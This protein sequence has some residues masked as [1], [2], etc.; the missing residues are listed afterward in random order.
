MAKNYVDI[1]NSVK[2]GN[3]MDWTNALQRKM[4][5]PVDLTGVYDSYEKAVIYAANDPVAYEGQFIGVTENGDTT[6][7]IITPAN[8]G[9]YTVGEGDDA[10][11]YEIHIKPI[12]VI[13][14]GDGKAVTVSEAGKISLV[15]IETAEGLTLPRMKEDKSGI[16]WVPVSQ[17]VEGDGNSVTIVEAADK[18]VDVTNIAEEDFE[19]YKY[20]VKVKLAD[21]GPNR[22]NA[23]KLFNHVDGQG[24]DRSG[25]YVE[26]PDPDVYTVSRL[27]G[28]Y[29]EGIIGHYYLGK[30]GEYV[31]GSDFKIPD[32][33]TMSVDEDGDEEHGERGSIKCYTFKQGDKLI[34]HIDIPTDLVVQ[35][36]SVV[37]ATEEDKALDEAVIVGDTYI[38]L[39]IANQDKPIYVHA[40]DLV[41]IYTVVD[42]SSVD[43]T[44]TGTEIKADVKISADEGNTLEIRGDGLYVNVPEIE[45]PEMPGVNATGDEG[46]TLTGT[47]DSENNEHVITATTNI[48]KEPGNIIQLKNDG[49]YAV[50]P[51]IIIPDVE[52]VTEVD[53]AVP[54]IADIVV[55]KDNKHQLDVSLV[56]VAPVKDGKIPEALLPEL[57]VAED[58]KHTHPTTENNRCDAIISIEADG[59]TIT[60]T[61]A[62]FVTADILRASDNKVADTAV[63]ADKIIWTEGENGYESHTAGGTLAEVLKDATVTTEVR[64]EIAEDGET[65]ITITHLTGGQSGFITPEEKFKLSKLVLGEDGS[66]GVSGT[67]S[68]DNVIGL[69][70][71]IKAEAPVKGA[72]IGDFIAINDRITIGEGQDLLLPLATVLRNASE[73]AYYAGMTRSKLATNHIVYD[74]GY[75]EVY[76]LSTDKLVNGATELVLNGGNAAGA[77]N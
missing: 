71:K 34:G 35:S 70:E 22:E 36:G 77:T 56:N 54:V 59:H 33:V 12:G 74:E 73:E 30:N 10:V 17:V 18:S 65:E 72:I 5:V 40:K 21:L 13:P 29:G 23:L 28:Y 4:G 66:V 3:V 76:A 42:T 39:V 7:Y 44:I 31:T 50:A 55:N 25:L 52:E 47:Y 14:T 19:G 51:D 64:T 26:L 46:V 57:I 8:Q 11:S 37:V 38:K 1:Q 48:S 68:A 45:M 67:I 69:P 16:E 6:A 61:V 43:M 75:G 15:G 58:V 24:E 49:F 63:F 27:G 2:A 9:A 60:P 62:S 20:Q 53:T 32:F 41:D